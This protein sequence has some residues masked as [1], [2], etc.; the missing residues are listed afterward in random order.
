MSYK[1]I[2]IDSQKSAVA[3]YSKFLLQYNQFEDVVICFVEGKD[4]DYYYPRVSK[5]ISSTKDIIFYPCN[6]RKEVEKVCEMIKSNLSIRKNIKIMYFC[7][8]DY[9]LYEKKEDIFYTDYYSIENYYANRDFIEKIIKRVFHINK[10]EE[11]YKICLDLFDKKQKIFHNSIIGV[12]AFCYSIREKEIHNKLPRTD[13]S[14]VTFNKL[15]LNN[16]FDDFEM[17]KMEYNFLLS[18]FNQDF[19]ITKRAFNKN[20]KIIDEYKYRG[21][22]ELEFIEWFLEELKKQVKSGLNGLEKRKSNLISFRN[23][24]MTSMQECALTSES[25]NKYINEHL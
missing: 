16:K 1:D 10:Y 17:R 4:I 6:G 22:W 19:K 13:F 5:R 8:R 25:L 3:A 2:L 20:K 21:K 24:I 18:L 11:D 9:D 7:D 23:E 14:K 12:N 15:V